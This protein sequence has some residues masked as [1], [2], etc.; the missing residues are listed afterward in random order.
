LVLVLESWRGAL[1][2][3]TPVSNQ[4][5][6]NDLEPA[7]LSLRPEIGDALARGLA[8]GADRMLVCGSGPTSIGIFWG[9]HGGQRARA[10]AQSLSA[11]Y[12][13]ATAAQPVRI[14]AMNGQQ[15]QAS[16]GS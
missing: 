12:P 8:A 5:I 2:A 6:V 16:H 14:S 15:S 11:A 4:L 9:E 7:A 3:N 13:G 1:A 10:A